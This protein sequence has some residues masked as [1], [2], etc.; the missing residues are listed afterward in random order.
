MIFY[1]LPFQNI[2]FV[3]PHYLFTTTHSVDKREKRGQ[4]R[5]IGFRGTN[6]SET[7]ENRF[8]KCFYWQENYSRFQKFQISSIFSTFSWFYDLPKRAKLLKTKEKL[9]KFQNVW[10]WLRFIAGLSH[11]VFEC[12]WRFLI[13]QLKKLAIFWKMV[14]KKLRVW[15]SV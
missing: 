12:R 13:V 15:W 7:W 2:Y 1:T 14:S 8:K 6:R 9:A 11:E 5:E 10:I 3:L 4:L